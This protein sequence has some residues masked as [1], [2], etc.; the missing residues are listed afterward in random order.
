MPTPLCRRPNHTGRATWLSWSW[1]KHRVVWRSGAACAHHNSA[2]QAP[3]CPR[4]SAV[5]PT[6][7]GRAEDGDLEC[8]QHVVQIGKLDLHNAVKSIEQTFEAGRQ[9]GKD[10]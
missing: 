5:V 4:R 8:V 9:L 7:C 10:V 6:R 2:V 3:R 1:P